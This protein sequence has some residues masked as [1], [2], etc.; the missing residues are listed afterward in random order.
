MY[1]AHVDGAAPQ[2]GDELYS[3]DMEGQSSGMIVN[4]AAAPGGGHDVLAVVQIASHDAHPI[5]LGSL[6]G[7]RLQFQSPPYP[8]P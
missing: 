6:A 4:A 5:H 3:A 1:L 7:A 8:L 2:P